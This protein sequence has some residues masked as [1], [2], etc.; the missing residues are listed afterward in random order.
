MAFGLLGRGDH[1]GLVPDQVGQVKLLEDPAER[2]AGR[3]VVPGGGHR[4]VQP[5]AHVIQRPLLDQHGLLQDVGKAADDLAQRSLVELHRHRPPELGFDPLSG[6]LLAVAVGIGQQPQLRYAVGEQQVG[7]RVD[8][9][10]QA[11]LILLGRGDQQ[12][13]RLLDQGQVELFQQEPGVAPQRHLAVAVQGRQPQEGLVR[14]ESDVVQ[15]PAIDDHVG[16]GPFGQHR[17]QLVDGAVAGHGRH[18]DL[19]EELLG[20]RVPAQ[21]LAAGAKRRGQQRRGAGPQ[22]HEHVAGR[23]VEKP[24]VR[25][26]RVQEG[27]RPQPGQGLL[28]Q[29][30]VLLGAGRQPRLGHLPEQPVRQRHV[31]RGQGLPRF[32]HRPAELRV[33]GAGRVGGRDHGQPVGRERRLRAHL[34]RLPVAAA[35]AP[36]DV[37]PAVVLLRLQDQEGRVRREQAPLPRQGHHPLAHVLVV[38]R[39]L[40]QLLQ[41]L[42]GPQPPYEH[43]VLLFGNRQRPLPRLGLAA[44]PGR[45]AELDPLGQGEAPIDAKRPAGRADRRAVDVLR[46][47]PVDLDLDHFLGRG[48]AGQQPA[49]QLALGAGIA[50][51][52]EGQPAALVGQ[53]LQQIQAP[54]APPH[55]H[56]E[57]HGA[58][59]LE[60]LRRCLGF[61]LLFAEEAELVVAVAD[62]DDQPAALGVLG[63]EVLQG[64]ADAG[65]QARSAQ[66]ELPVQLGQGR[67]GFVAARR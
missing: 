15:C 12:P 16:P 45:Q 14:L 49:E 38:K 64:V 52:V 3:H 2:L 35:L 51:R 33:A 18:A 28:A 9:G 31:A 11:V 17:G 42:L 39:R 29:G 24:A 26:E 7:H 46:R 54:L 4:T 37:P 66:G 32:A 5:D 23:R 56:A 25:A 57:H 41:A 63:V 67:A 60:Q 62:V 65:V 59:L 6:G 58:G 50:G 61:R 19:L 1:Q 8:L 13:V 44:A 48:Q 53:R 21:E 40:A 34:G 27:L 22:V 30:G 10:R 36:V 55:G 20:I 47:G 43:V